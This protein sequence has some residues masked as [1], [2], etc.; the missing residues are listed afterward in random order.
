[1]EINEIENK[2]NRKINKTF[3]L[4]RSDQ[5]REKNTLITSIIH[6][7]SDITTDSTDIKR[8]IRKYGKQ[9]YVNQFNNLNE[10]DKFTGRQKL[11]KFT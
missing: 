6:K 2:N 10:I 9:L 8:I 4:T 5:S 1:M 11:P 3:P 7:K